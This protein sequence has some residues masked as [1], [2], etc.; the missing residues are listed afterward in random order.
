MQHVNVVD[1]ADAEQDELEDLFG[2]R[3]CHRALLFQQWD[4]FLSFDL[5]A[6]D[7]LLVVPDLTIDLFH[8]LGWVQ[9]FQY[10][11]FCFNVFDWNVVFACIFNV[12]NFDCNFLFWIYNFTQINSTKGSLTKFFDYFIF[13]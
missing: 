7:E 1:V 11:D 8:D 2:L 6:H 3:L 9:F 10:F 13:I 5:L 12:Y 4:Q